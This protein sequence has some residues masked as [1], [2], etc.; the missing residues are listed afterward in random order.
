MQVYVQTGNGTW[1]G[2][3]QPIG[4]L[5]THAWNTPTVTVPSSAVTPLS[6]LGVQF[7]TSGAWTGTCYVD[8]ISW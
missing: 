5:K 3:W 7:A 2:K 8:S 4:N 6:A 1:T